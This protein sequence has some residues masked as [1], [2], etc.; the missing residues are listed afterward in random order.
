MARV[1][2]LGWNALGAPHGPNEAHI[3]CQMCQMKGCVSV[4][5]VRVKSG[6]SG[7]AILLILLA[8]PTLGL[9]LLLLLATGLSG[10]EYRN[11]ATCS[12]CGCRWYF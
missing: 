4:G 3:V 10:H 12:N 9:S 5:S 7:A 1:Q 11:L 2:Q 6:I 8:V